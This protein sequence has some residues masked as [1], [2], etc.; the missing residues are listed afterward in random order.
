M[1][2]ITKA[3]QDHEAELRTFLQSRLKD[4]HQTEDLLQDI[5]IK[6]L[7]EGTQFC[8]LENSRAWLFRVA[9]NQMIDYQR[10]Q[11]EHDDIP[12]QV[13]EKNVEATPVANLSTCLPVALKE[14]NAEDQEII[15]RCDLDGMNQADYAKLKGLSLTGAKSRIQRARKRLKDQLKITCHIIFDEQGNVCCFGDDIKETKNKLK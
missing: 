9:K 7:A 13:A 12:E 15:Q 6:A 4:T 1:N 10:T 5:F 8:D 3:W 2:C 14:M 11:K